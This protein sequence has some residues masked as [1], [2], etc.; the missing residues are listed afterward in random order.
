MA[1]NFSN[2]LT[3]AAE[4]PTADGAFALWTDAE[5]YLEDF[6]DFLETSQ[7]TLPQL[8]GPLQGLRFPQEHDVSNED[9]RFSWFYHF[10]SE[11]EQ[12]HSRHG[13]FH[14]FAGPAMFDDPVATEKTH[15][16]AIELN[17]DG[18]LRG[19]FIPNRWTTGE[20]MRS[21]KI[22]QE[23]IDQFDA[24][25]GSPNRAIDLWLAAMMRVFK[26]EISAL[27]TRRDSYLSCLS[28][29]RRS[30]YLEDQNVTRIC[31]WVMT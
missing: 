24:S 13:H 29:T 20:H 4:C 31:E 5:R 28:P 14:L 11:D 7:T 16:I 2:R 3:T 9:G 19:F 26:N 8:I 27:L 17:E 18:D 21:A 25:I 10:H 1:Q 6:A 15:M 30:Q 12:S 23:C 22:L